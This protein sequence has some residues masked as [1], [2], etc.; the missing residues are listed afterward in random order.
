MRIQEYSAAGNATAAMPLLAFAALYYFLVLQD[1]PTNSQRQSSDPLVQLL[2]PVGGDGAILFICMGIGVIWLALARPDFT[3]VKRGMLF[4]VGGVVAGAS[5][6]SLLHAGF[7]DT[8]P[9][10]VPREESAAP[11]MALGVGAGVIE[12]ALFRLGVLPIAFFLLRRHV[13]FMAAAAGACLVT[14]L[15]F[16][17]SHEVGPAALQ[18]FDL[19]HFMT[20]VI[21]PGV[22]M[23]AVAFLIHPSFIVSAHCAA[24]VLIAALFVA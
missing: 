1:P 17:L 11:G 9:A 5:V 12:E 18:A 23:S 7:G 24:H 4:A 19:A 6:V 3:E 13:G 14:G 10:F 8:L 15:V 21:I 22:A 20:R 2:F 16:A